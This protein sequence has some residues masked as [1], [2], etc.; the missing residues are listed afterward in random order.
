MGFYDEISKYYDDIFPVDKEQ[1]NFLSET[2]GKPPKYL[3]DIACGTGGY[4]L[5]LAKLGYKVTAV[6]LDEKMVKE[7]K[8]KAE[9]LNIDIQAIQSNML[10][11][12]KR[13]NNKFDLAFC[14]GNSLVHLAGEREIEKFLKEM[15]GMLNENG[16][17]IVQIINYDRVLENKVSFLPTIKNAERGLEFS[18]IYGYDSEKSKILFKTVLKVD[19]NIIENEIALYPI[20]AD[21]LVNLVHKAGFENVNIYGDLEG[22]EFNK[23]SSYVL[24]LSAS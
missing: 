10:D 3:L 5:E 12:D 14:I 18:R 6:D 7:L 9:N 8:N 1:V 13:I 11:I 16:S 2:S 15:K 24:V 21:N 23:N 17:L 20:L 19:G 4:S 22:V